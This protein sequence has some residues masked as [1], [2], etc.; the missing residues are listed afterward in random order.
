MKTTFDPQTVD[1]AKSGGL[2]PVVI[3]D[4]SN[5]AVLMLGY[6]NEAALQATL[7]SGRVTFYSR[8]KGRLWEKGERSGNTL[9]VHNICSDCDQ[10]ALLVLAAPAGPTCHTGSRSCFG[11]RPLFSL[12][13]L[14]ELERTIR[15][16]KDNPRDNSYT[17]SLFKSGLARIAQKVG[18]EGV[19]V[20]LAGALQADNL[21]DET[22]DLLYHALVLLSANQKS[23]ADVLDV[24]KQ[25]SLNHEAQ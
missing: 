24:L 22:A 17:C 3:Q 5:G 2:V 9:F 6:M 23:L 1:W 12:A 16:R 7:L 20:A 8:S 19:E 25:R 15:D 18:E 14:D 11:E 13:T 4:A 21:A 10:D